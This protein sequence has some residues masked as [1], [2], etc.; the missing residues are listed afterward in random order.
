MIFKIM[1][2]GDTCYVNYSCYFSKYLFFTVTSFT[3][4]I[5]SVYPNGDSPKSFFFIFKAVEV[6]NVSKFD[7]FSLFA[8]N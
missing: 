5:P 3:Q 2:Q 1:R 4:L 6:I 8:I 7:V